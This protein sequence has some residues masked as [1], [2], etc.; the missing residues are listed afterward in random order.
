[1]SCLCFENERQEEVV[2]VPSCYSATKH[3]SRHVPFFF[4]SSLLHVSLDSKLPY[5][6]EEVS[7]HFGIMNDSSNWTNPALLPALT[8]TLHYRPFSF[9]LSPAKR[10]SFENLKRV[11]IIHHLHVH[12]SLVS[13]PCYGSRSQ[14][15]GTVSCSPDWRLVSIFV[16]APLIS[17]FISCTNSIVDFNVHGI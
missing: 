8:S 4:L 2:L 9:L 3:V 13:S 15:D 14:N 7:S 1:M 6:K 12:E 16:C 10:A 11:C 5:A 17:H